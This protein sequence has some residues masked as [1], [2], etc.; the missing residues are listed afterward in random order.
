MRK[1]VVSIVGILAMIMALHA[2]T[3]NTK[4]TEILLTNVEALSDD[5]EETIHI[6]CC[7][8]KNTCAKG[9]KVTIKGKYS[10]EPCK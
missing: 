1:A 8:T 5:A 4:D 10:N 7:G 3:Q 9:D 2:I 6:W